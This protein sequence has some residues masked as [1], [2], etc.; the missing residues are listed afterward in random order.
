MVYRRRRSYSKRP[1]KRTFRGRY[2]RYRKRPIRQYSR[3]ITRMTIR[4][5]V[6]AD[7]TFVKLTRNFSYTLT[8][9]NGENFAKV[10]I[11]GNG[12]L[13][14]VNSV[15]PAGLSQW[16]SFYKCYRIMGASIKLIAYPGGNNSEDGVI[17]GVTPVL[18]INDSFDRNS[19]PGQPYTK[20]KIGS[21]VN[22]T[23]IKHVMNSKKMFGQRISTEDNYQG[24]MSYDYSTDS[25]AVDDPL[26][27]WYFRVWGSRP[28]ISGAF[29]MNFYIT[30][31][32]YVQLED[33]IDAD[34]ATIADNDP[35][36]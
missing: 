16:A 4:P 15:A 35:D 26:T 2:R 19:A 12:F 13:D 3:R 23:I 27:Q 18:T 9:P 20:W 21:D 14:T 5:T 17:F 31:T 34:G 8:I 32:Y 24:T 10:N 22:P 25:I 1:V 11:G 30:V 28:G 6:M 29:P 36:E 7:K 33:R